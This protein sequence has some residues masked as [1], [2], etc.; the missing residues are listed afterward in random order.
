MIFTLP[1]SGDENLLI[2]DSDTPW[3]VCLG[4]PSLFCNTFKQIQAATWIHAYQSRLT[5]LSCFEM[6]RLLKALGGIFMAMEHLNLYHT[7]HCCFYMGYSSSSPSNSVVVLAEWLNKTMFCFN[8]YFVSMR[9]NMNNLVKIL[10]VHTS[11]S[12]GETA[13]LGG[14]DLRVALEPESR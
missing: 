7:L 6:T 13:C 12:E 1:F 11:F 5:K 14:E 2:R 8:F 4:I 10:L 9:I 3:P